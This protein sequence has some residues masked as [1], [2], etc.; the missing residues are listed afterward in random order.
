[1]ANEQ[2]V[3]PLGSR[4]VGETPVTRARR[5][6]DDDVARTLLD[7]GRLCADLRRHAV[8]APP[9]LALKCE[10]VLKALSAALAEHFGDAFAPPPRQTEDPAPQ[11]FARGRRGVRDRGKGPGVQVKR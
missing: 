8:G 11:W 7:A 9:Q 3:V 5:S 10:I 1:V 2:F 6:S 4:P